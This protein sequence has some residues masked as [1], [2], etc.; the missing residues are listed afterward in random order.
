MRLCGFRHTSCIQG[1]EP[2]PG[3]V[4]HGSLGCCHAEYPG[5][6]ACEVPGHE[7]LVEG[8]GHGGIRH[9]CA[10]GVEV[11][12]VVGGVLLGLYHVVL[13]VVPVDTHRV[14]LVAGEGG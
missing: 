11:G 13:P 12:V 1:V 5:V 2:V 4:L 7:P 10:E 14:V 6:E 3:L 8:P 9:A